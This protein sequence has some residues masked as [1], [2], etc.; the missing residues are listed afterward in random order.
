MSD[1]K[2]YKKLPDGTFVEYEMWES[3]IVNPGFVSNHLSII[4]F[5]PLI[6]FLILVFI[7]LVFC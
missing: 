6:I 1:R 5:I 2:L 3:G 7:K 4:P